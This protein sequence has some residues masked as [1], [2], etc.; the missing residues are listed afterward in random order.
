MRTALLR[1]PQA[2]FDAWCAKVL[3]ESD[4]RQLGGVES[5]SLTKVPDSFGGYTFTGELRPA[6][7]TQQDLDLGLNCL[8]AQR[9]H[10]AVRF[11]GMPHM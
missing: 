1:A 5:A 7:V 6:L 4:E 11:Y 3:A 8:P 2:V 10:A 9:E